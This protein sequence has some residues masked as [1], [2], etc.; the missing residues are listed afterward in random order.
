MTASGLLGRPFPRRTR[1]TASSDAASQ[2]SW[3]PPTPFTATNPP[4]AIALT[5]ASSGPAG[6]CDATPAGA[7]VATSAGSHHSRGPQRGHATGSAWKRRSAGSEYSAAQSAHSGKPAIAVRARSYGRS[8]T[9]VARGPQSV[10]L[11]NGYRWRRSAGSNSSRRQAGQVARSGA[12]SRGPGGT[13]PADSR[14]RNAPTGTAPA[15]TSSARTVVTCA[16][17]GT[18]TG[19]RSRNDA[20]A[21]GAPPARI[22]TCPPA[23]RTYPRSPC[24]TASRYT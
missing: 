16:A 18:S 19:S 1:S 21:A 22:T 5:A 6:A 17:G 2:T 8:S 12:T 11:R 7:W 15:G 10:Q 3:Y 20:N 24:A 23:L 14:T 4:A 9:M 13:V